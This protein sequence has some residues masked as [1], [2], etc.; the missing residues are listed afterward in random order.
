MGIL[1]II[2][3]IGKAKAYLKGKKT[4]ISSVIGMLAS[5]AA[6]LTLVVQ[7]AD[8]T[9]STQQFIDQVQVPAGAFWIAITFLWAALHPKNILPVPD[10][11]QPVKK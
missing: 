6:V 11:N 3:V 10:P 8:G 1:N 9:L 7:W 2:S 5:G 4:I